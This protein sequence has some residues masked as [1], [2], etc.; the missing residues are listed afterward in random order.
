[1]EGISLTA[2]VVETLCYTVI[3]GYSLFHKYVFSSY[4]DV[5]ACW[6]QNILLCGMLAWYRKAPLRVWLPCA[7]AFM[8]YNWWVISGA[9]GEQM[10]LLGQV[11][12]L[13]GRARCCV[14]R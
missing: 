5:F 7:I 11:R 13:R 6:I 9:C 1:M 4:G 14:Q 12:S 8:A 3:V 2:T 10:L